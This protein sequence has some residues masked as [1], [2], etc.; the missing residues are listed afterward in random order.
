[1]ANEDTDI[2]EKVKII[3]AGQTNGWPKFDGS[4]ADPMNGGYYS[5]I[6]K[7]KLLVVNGFEVPLYFL[8]IEQWEIVATF[9]RQQ[10]PNGNG[11]VTQTNLEFP[12]K[13]NLRTLIVSDTLEG[14]EEIS[15]GLIYSGR[16]TIIEVEYRPEMTR[17]GIFDRFMHGEI[18]MFQERI[19]EN[20]RR[21]DN[22][23]TTEYSPG[24]SLPNPISVRV[25]KVRILRTKE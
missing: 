15:A 23:R 3:L 20:Y 25:Q 5:E 9:V 13:S 10:K 7:R 17:I 1:M 2:E 12:I 19:G 16:G 11:M 24:I 18:R 21:S 8:G 6:G 14:R 4:P 22:L